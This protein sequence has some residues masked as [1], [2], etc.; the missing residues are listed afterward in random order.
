MFKN[1]TLIVSTCL[2][3]VTDDDD[4]FYLFLQKQKIGAKLH[5]YL[6]SCPDTQVMTLASSPPSSRCL[7]FRVCQTLRFLLSQFCRT[8]RSVFRQQFHPCPC[9]RIMTLA[10]SPPSA[11]CPPFRHE[12]CLCLFPFGIPS[13]F[14]DQ[15]DVSQYT[16][17]V[18]I[19]YIY[20]MS[21][22]SVYLASYL[23]WRSAIMTTPNGLLF[24]ASCETRSRDP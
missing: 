18:Y 9:T 10:P 5:I 19:H 3:T 7:P 4:V 1:S 12:C 16:V 23:G 24:V 14:R 11:R 13:I 15:N 17:Y 2:P 20:T 22:Q 6:G 8:E 21:I